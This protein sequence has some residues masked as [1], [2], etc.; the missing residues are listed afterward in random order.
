MAAE[1]WPG[2]NPLGKCFVVGRP[3]SPCRTVVGVVADVRLFKIF[4]QPWLGVYLPQA[5]T[6]GS[7]LPPAVIAVDVGSSDL[8]V[9]GL[10]LRQILDGEAGGGF[11]WQV[12]SFAS[13]AEPE[14][15]PWR[16]SAVLVGVLGI[17]AAVVTA[18]GA[19][20]TASY[21]VSQRIHE[22]SVRRV[23]GAET[24]DLVALVMWGTLRLVA[25]G[26]LAGVTIVLVLGRLAGAI[27]YGVS[28]HD[29]LTLSLAMI[30]EFVAAIAACIVPTWYAA[31]VQPTVALASE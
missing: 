19:Y 15:R 7:F 4:E 29:P 6:Q 9:T 31:R 8:R 10:R 25:I 1:Y 21:G 13:L 30:I 16:L 14:F 3:D 27:L 2:E 12:R 5:Q 11:K 17:V 23:L 18:I 26:T 24:T 28:A 20:G 22:L